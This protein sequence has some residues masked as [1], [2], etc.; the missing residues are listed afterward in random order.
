VPDTGIW[1]RLVIEGDTVY[2]AHDRLYVN[3]DYILTAAI[4]DEPRR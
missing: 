4:T 3:R 2:T 1:V